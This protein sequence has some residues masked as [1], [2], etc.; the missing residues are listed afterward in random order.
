MQKLDVFAV[1]RESWDLT[2]QNLNPLLGASLLTFV[3]LMASAMLLVQLFANMQ[4]LD[5]SDAEQLKQAMEPVQLLL[6]LLLAPFEAALAYMGW[7]RATGQKTEMSM[8]F[9]GWAMAVPLS[10]I[11][12]VTAVM[13]NLGLFMLILPGVYLMAVLSQA[14]LYYLFHRGSPI[15]AM[16]ESAKVVH[17]QVFAVI[18]VYSAMIAILMMA[19]IPAGLGL[20]LAVPMFFHMKGVLFRE[21]FP[22]LSPEQAAPAQPEAPEERGSD[23]SFEA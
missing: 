17:R 22:E 6:V 5:L 1:I 2:R 9:R 21:L 14:N 4:G 12:L 7:R 16:I 11:A 20:V 18:T 3:I 8:V 10:L 23:S 15:K 19:M 13:V